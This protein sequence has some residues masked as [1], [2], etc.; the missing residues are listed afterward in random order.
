MQLVAALTLPRTQRKRV[1]WK[2]KRNRLQ[3]IY[4][5]GSFET[6]F[7]F[8]RVR[9]WLNETTDRSTPISQCSR[10]GQRTQFISSA[11][12]Q[13]TGDRDRVTVHQSDYF[14]QNQQI[15]PRFKLQR[16]F[17]TTLLSDTTRRKTIR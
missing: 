3:N 12:G 17:C 1:G 6:A 8:R 16:P 11:A 7:L 13:V 14:H 10:P 2:N 9:F 4:Y 5:V 15:A